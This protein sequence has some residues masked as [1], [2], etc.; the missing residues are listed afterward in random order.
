M[1]SVL[2]ERIKELCIMH[3]MTP[4]RLAELVGVSVSSIRK[5]QTTV[6]SVEK[7]KAVAEYFDVSI[8][9][10]T[11]LTEIAVTA[12][13][14]IEDQAFIDML[15]EE[16]TH[17]RRSVMRFPHFSADA[18][19]MAKRWADLDE[20]GRYAVNAIIEAEEHRMRNPVKEKRNRVIPLFGNSFA[21]GVGEPDFGNALEEYEVD[22]DV[23]ADFAVRVNG[24][25]MEP[26]LHDNQIVLGV[27][28][29]PKIGDIIAIMVDG[30]F[31]V[32]QYVKDNFGNLYLLSLN[33]K[34]QDVEVKASADSTVRCFG[35]IQIGRSIPLAI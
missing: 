19:R 20:G 4:E 3:N 2:Y 11:G 1:A 15:R 24:E 32:K 10:L 17:D 35:I 6:P 26:Y 22:E 31:Y 16:S 18:L 8:D 5:W 28:G 9:Y 7:V 30:A 25:S 12:E 14:L 13:R 34:Y 33:R 21:A 29:M 23:K 27:K